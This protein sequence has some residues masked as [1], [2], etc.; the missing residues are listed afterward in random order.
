MRGLELAVVF[1]FQEETAAAAEA[2][3]RLRPS[4][5]FVLFL[6]LLFLCGA[7]AAV[8]GWRGGGAKPQFDQSA[9]GGVSAGERSSLGRRVGS[10]K[11][12]LAGQESRNELLFVPVG[13][14]SHTTA[15]HCCQLSQPP[16]DLTLP[17]T[18]P[19]SLLLVFLF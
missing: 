2:S 19:Q 13:G 8:G 11:L 16:W 7:Y 4:A 9:G 14:R 10:S 1:F 15:H 6:L 18:S 12:S 17:E 5:A 3:K